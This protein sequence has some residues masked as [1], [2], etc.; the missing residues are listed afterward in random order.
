MRT[1]LYVVVCATGVSMVLN[2]VGLV[3]FKRK[4]VAESQVLAAYFYRYYGV[5]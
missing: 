5:W 3:L 4:C 1:A 2:V